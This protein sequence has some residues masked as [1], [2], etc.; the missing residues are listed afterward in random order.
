MRPFNTVPLDQRVG[1][2]RLQQSYTMRVMYFVYILRCADKT[3]YTGITT[4]VDRRFSEHASGRGAAYTRAKKAGRIVYVEARA[5]RSA[6]LVREA[7]IKK[8][9]KIHKEKLIGRRRVRIAATPKM[10]Y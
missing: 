2:V 4:D 1:F 9:S 10:V 8:L 6:A 5:S 7:A 3:L